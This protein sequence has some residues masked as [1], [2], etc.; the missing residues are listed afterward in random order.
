MKSIIAFLAVFFLLLSCKNFQTVQLE[1]PT[2]PVNPNKVLGKLSKYNPL[3][4][5]NGVLEDFNNDNH[6]WKK[7]SDSLKVLTVGGFLTIET[8]ISTTEDYVYGLYSPL[9][10]SKLSAIEVNYKADSISAIPIRLG[11]VDEQETIHI[12]FPFN[13]E[14]NKL[15]FPLN[16]HEIPGHFQLNRVTQILL[17][18]GNTDQPLKGKIYIDQIKAIQ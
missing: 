6:D 4:I 17:I 7:S 18:P 1:P 12:L 15:I 9:D 3:L 2:E 8:L 5:N 11:L 16:I 14:N 13:T 10:F